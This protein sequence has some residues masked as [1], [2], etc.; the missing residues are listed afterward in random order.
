M[1]YAEIT[2]AVTDIMKNLETAQVKAKALL[3][4][5]K[6]DYETLDTTKQT[7]AEKEEKIRDLQD[8]NM[9][10]FLQQ[11]SPV[12]EDKEEEELEGDDAINA[13]I[14]QLNQSNK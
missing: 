6:A 7:L 1:T 2:N 3:E 5:I 4:G 9:K 11:T 8:T 13:F 12:E 14:T 10:L